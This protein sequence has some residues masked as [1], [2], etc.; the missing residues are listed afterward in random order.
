MNAAAA[1]EPRRDAGARKKFGR[2]MTGSEAYN[3]LAI[4]SDTLIGSMRLS[5]SRPFKSRS[6]GELEL[7][8]RA[9]PAAFT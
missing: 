3:A 8:V 6:D 7:G 5:D 9:G 1:R 2:G 4:G